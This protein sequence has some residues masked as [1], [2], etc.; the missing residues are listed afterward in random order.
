MAAILVKYFTM[1]ESEEV[2]EAVKALVVA[3]QKEYLTA[4]GILN[5]Y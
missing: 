1:G 3:A 4:D 5:K 2:K